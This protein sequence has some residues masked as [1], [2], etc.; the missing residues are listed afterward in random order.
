MRIWD[1]KGASVAGKKRVSFSSRK[2]MVMLMEKTGQRIEPYNEFRIASVSK[3]I[4][5]TAM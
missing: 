4:T 5:A 1:L 2:V 3:L